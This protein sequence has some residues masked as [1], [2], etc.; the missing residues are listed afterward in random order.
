MDQV[1]NIGLGLSSLAKRFMAIFLIIMAVKDGNCETESAQATASTHSR[2][3][4]D[5][6]TNKGERRRIAG[7]VIG[8]NERGV[9]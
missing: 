3:K 8:E 2:D 5:F 1:C 4:N 9:V 7:G 6:T